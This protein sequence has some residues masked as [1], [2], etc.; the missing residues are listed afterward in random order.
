[1]RNPGRLLQFRT[2]GQAPARLPSAAGG[3]GSA[4]GPGNLLERQL[5]LQP[6]VA[7]GGRKAG[8]DVTVE[9]RLRHYAAN[10]MLARAPGAC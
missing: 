6:P 5:A 10:Q 9:A 3:Q 8:A 1:M 2:G 7:E 4:R